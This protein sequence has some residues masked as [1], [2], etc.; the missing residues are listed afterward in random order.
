MIDLSVVIVNHNT[1]KLVLECLDSMFGR[2]QSITYEVVV[3]DNESSDGSVEAVREQY[4]Q[5]KLI[6]NPVGRFFSAGTNQGIAIAEGRYILALNPD[7]LVL[8]DTLGQLV[9]QMDAN[10]D[11][12]AAT[13]LQYLPGK[14]LITNGSRQVTYRYL[15]YQYTFLG[16]LFPSQLEALRNWLWYKGWERTTQQDVGVLAGSCLIA[17]RETWKTVGGFPEKLPF[18]FTEDYVTMKVAQLG[19]RTVHLVTDGIIH[20]EGATTFVA[21]KRKLTRR[22]L[23]AYLRNLL[24]YTDMV[25]GRPA[26]FLL[27]A[28]IAPTWIVQWLRAK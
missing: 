4:P 19:K 3:V 9:R 25:F 28:L 24:T 15:L 17:A 7:T 18:Y 2:P 11:I 27:A 10:P 22:Y 12:G 16:K 5:V 1:R 26:Q 14:Q 23:N 21:G 13:T 6:A 20:Y 8:G